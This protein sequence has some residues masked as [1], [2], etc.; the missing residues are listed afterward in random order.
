LSE[1]TELQSAD[2]YCR[3]LA[4]RHYE[5]FS[6]ASY[7]LPAELR[8]HLARVY[9]FARTTDD[10]GDESSGD[11]LARLGSWRDQFIASYA[12]KTKPIHPVLIALAETIAAFDLPSQPFLDL[13][14]ANVQDQRVHEYHTWTELDAYCRLSATPVG[15]LVLAIFGV[16][17]ARAEQLSDDVCIGLQ[18][19]NHAQDVRRDRDKG[20]TYLLQSDLQTGGVTGAVQSMTNR[21]ATLLASGIELEQMVPGRLGLQ[22]ALY[23]LG[24]MAVVAAIEQIGYRTDQQRPH[25]SKLEKAKIVTVALKRGRGRSAH[26]PT[27]PNAETAPERAAGGA[28][29]NQSPT[30]APA[31]QRGGE[32][33]WPSTRAK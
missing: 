21:A 17:D 8:R 7:I 31:S 30:S 33:E 1:L 5:N 28:A 20:R 9:A 12:G 16:H 23:R 2:A 18:L 13:I 10:F 29:S 22:L 6:V 27:Q 3:Y 14:A 24:G 11:A 26:A 15:R 32:P 19:A 4:N 25:V